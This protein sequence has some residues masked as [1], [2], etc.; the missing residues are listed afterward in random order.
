MQLNSYKNKAE[1]KGKMTE[2]IN[3]NLILRLEREIVK[4]HSNLLIT[5]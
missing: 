4:K 2:N 5:S 3:K 1:N